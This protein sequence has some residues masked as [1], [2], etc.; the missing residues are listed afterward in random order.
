MRDARHGARMLAKSPAFTLL[1]IV[2]LALGISVNVTMFGVVN[3][4][5]FK[6]FAGDRPQELVEVYAGDA[7]ARTGFSSHSYIDYAVIACWVPAQRA[8]RVDPMTSLR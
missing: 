3:S 8:T 4:A 1:A 6:P 5:L 2:T 7:D